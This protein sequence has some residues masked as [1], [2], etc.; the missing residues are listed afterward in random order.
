MAYQRSTKADGFKQRKVADLS[1]QQKELAANLEKDNRRAV[2]Q[3]QKV[4]N[5]QLQEMAR[6]DKLDLAAD[7]Y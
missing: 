5:Q 4:S 6:T 1:K 3:F 7:K 2:S